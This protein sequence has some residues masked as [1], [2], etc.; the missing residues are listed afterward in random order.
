MDN[1]IWCVLCDK[2]RESSNHLFFECEKARAVWNEIF[3]WWHLNPILPT[4]FNV[5][6]LWNQSKQFPAKKAKMSWKV[7]VSAVLWCLWI[8]RN[9]IVFDGISVNFSH[10]GLSIKH[11]AKEWC[12]A[13]NLIHSKSVA[14][15]LLNPM[16]AVTSSERI[17]IK[18]LKEQA[19]DLVGFID[20]SCKKRGN[21][22]KAGRGGI[23]FNKNDEAIFTFSEP[24]TASTPYEAE[25]QAFIYLVQALENSVWRNNSILIYSDCMDVVRDALEISVG[26]NQ[27]GSRE[28][29]D[30]IRKIRWKIKHIPSD[31]NITA[32]QLAKRG[33][34]SNSPFALWAHN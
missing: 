4:E 20:G 15:W 14:W 31:L 34:A 30:I 28:V 23:I 16:G 17:Q 26:I 33:A 18:D 10:L 25:W 32:D 13:F 21:V 7:V 19:D 24:I 29:T 3:Q 27:R 8:T 1:N 11:Q 2:V 5:R 12:L 6:S 22:I 9:K